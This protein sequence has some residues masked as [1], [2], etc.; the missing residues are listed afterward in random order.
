VLVSPSH[1]IKELVAVIKTQPPIW[2]LFRYLHLLFLRLVNREKQ[3]KGLAEQS[4][5]RKHMK[6]NILVSADWF[7]ENIPTWSSIFDV[8]PPRVRDSEPKGTGN[9]KL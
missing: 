3:K 8:L 1:L 4:N 9:W 5:F 6:E 2:V 7:T